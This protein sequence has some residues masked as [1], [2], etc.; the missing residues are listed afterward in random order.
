MKEK[1]FPAVVQESVGEKDFWEAFHEVWGNDRGDG[2]R[3]PD[4]D[5]KA[6]MYVQVKMEAHFQ[7]S[8]STKHS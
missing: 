2:E 6:W 7:E 8:K 1:D 5:K 4:Y 3:R